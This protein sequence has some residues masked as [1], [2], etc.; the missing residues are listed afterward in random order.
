[1]N[2]RTFSTSRL[3]R[4][5]AALLGVGLS[6]VLTCSTPARADEVDRKQNEITCEDQV[7]LMK[8]D[9][10][11]LEPLNKFLSDRK[12]NLQNL[13]SACILF[14]VTVGEVDEMP[15]IVTGYVFEEEYIESYI[16]G[17]MDALSFT[18]TQAVIYYL[19]TQPLFLLKRLRDY[20]AFV[21]DK[22]CTQDKDLVKQYLAQMTTFIGFV[23][24]LPKPEDCGTPEVDAAPA[25]AVALAS[26]APSPA[27]SPSVSPAPSP[28]SSPSMPSPPPA[29]AATPAP[30]PSLSS[31]AWQA[32]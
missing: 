16:A 6:M 26:P 21:V 2:A 13:E 9:L 27:P 5:W 1:M 10:A 30:A 7:D 28:A 12:D 25:P 15:T 3:I 23:N 22:K 4:R 11:F 29:P 31:T 14:N 32:W 17:R 8:M 19:K 18:R 20:L 24:Q